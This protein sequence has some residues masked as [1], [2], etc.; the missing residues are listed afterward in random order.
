MLQE[1]VVGEQLAKTAFQTATLTLKE[2]SVLDYSAVS[3]VQVLGKNTIR[4]EADGT[5]ASTL[6]ETGAENLLPYA[7]SLLL[8]GFAL[9]KASNF[10]RKAIATREPIKI[11]VK[12]IRNA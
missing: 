4:F 5:A 9:M 3:S 6:P 11:S 10:R 7:L 8:A 12:P 2:G 1:R